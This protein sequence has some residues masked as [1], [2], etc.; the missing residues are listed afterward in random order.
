[1]EGLEA[2]L[3]VLFTLDYQGVKQY[4]EEHGKDCIFSE[5]DNHNRTSLHYYAMK[6]SKPILLLLLE[7]LK[8][9]NENSIN[10]HDKKGKT[11]LHYAC[12]EGHQ[13]VVQILLDHGAN[14]QVANIGGQTAIHY[15]S[16]KGNLGILK[17]LDSHGADLKAKNRDEQVALHYACQAGHLDIVV[18]LVEEKKVNI[19]ALTKDHSLPIH[20]AVAYKR[21]A[22]VAFLLDHPVVIPSSVFDLESSE[23]I[24]T[25]LEDYIS[26]DRE[27]RISERKKKE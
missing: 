21:D 7:T 25:M 22:I 27:T 5:M 15:A 18:W 24:T 14:P 20:F 9:I 10:V 19:N 3:P 11:A 1:M 6:G 2:K 16:F 8:G 13:D 12:Q 26:T 23:N 4:I 17:L